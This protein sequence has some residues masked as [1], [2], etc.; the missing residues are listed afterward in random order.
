[1][2]RMMAF[3]V[4]LQYLALLISKLFLAQVDV[5]NSVTAYLTPLDEEACN[6][7]MFVSPAQTWSEINLILYESQGHLY[8][9]CVKSLQYKGS[10]LKYG[11]AEPYAKKYS[12]PLLKRGTYD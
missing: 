11:Y 6:W 7:M 5:G 9:V 8:F 10:E 1:M 2:L 3:N 12:L 4:N